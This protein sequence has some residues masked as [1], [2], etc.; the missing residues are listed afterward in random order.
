MSYSNWTK[1]LQS[2][3]PGYKSVLWHLIGRVRAFGTTPAVPTHISQTGPY[4][5]TAS[6][7]QYS[8]TKNS[9]SPSTKKVMLFAATVVLNV[10]FSYFYFIAFVHEI[11]VYFHGK[12]IMKI[13]ASSRGLQLNSTF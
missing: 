2:E 13:I 1:L 11:K 9:T 6:Y 12:V 5:Q 10:I 7:C 4:F 3:V 8:G